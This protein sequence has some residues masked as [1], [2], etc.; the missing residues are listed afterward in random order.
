MEKTEAAG[1]S[2]EARRHL[3]LAQRSHSQAKSKL[4]PTSMRSNIVKITRNNEGPHLAPLG[5]TADIRTYKSVKM[6]I[7]LVH[8]IHF[9]ERPSRDELHVPLKTHTQRSESPKKKPKTT[10]PGPRNVD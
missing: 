4:Y 5:D 3:Y 9:E 1:P 10:Q 7:K 6:Q 2:P 8:N